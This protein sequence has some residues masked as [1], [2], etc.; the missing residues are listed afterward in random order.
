MKYVQ[1]LLDMLRMKVYVK[2][3]KNI[4]AFPF[5]RFFFKLIITSK[6]PDTISS[7]SVKAFRCVSDWTSYIFKQGGDKHI[8]LHQKHSIYLLFKCVLLTTCFI[9][10]SKKF[11]YWMAKRYYFSKEHILWE[12][13]E[14]IYDIFITTCINFE[15]GFLLI[16]VSAFRVLS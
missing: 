9:H 5:C 11:S 1:V 4:C 6:N 3:S 14:S 8:F 2:T 15:L 16:K 7:Y 13:L 12:E 10:I